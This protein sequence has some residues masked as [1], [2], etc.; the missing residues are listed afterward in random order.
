MCHIHT[1]RYVSLP[2]PAQYSVARA[3]YFCPTLTK[4]ESS[5]RAQPVSNSHLVFYV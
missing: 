5:D 1:A 4:L 2:G 3:V